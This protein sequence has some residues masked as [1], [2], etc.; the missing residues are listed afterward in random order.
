MYEIAIAHRSYLLD[1]KCCGIC[2][3]QQKLLQRKKNI[4]GLVS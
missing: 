3:I 4:A 2:V 1:N